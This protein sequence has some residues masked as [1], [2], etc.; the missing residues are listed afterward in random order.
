VPKDVDADD[1]PAFASAKSG[2]TTKL[3]Q[4]GTGRP[5]NRRLERPTSACDSH[6]ER[7][8][9][10]GGH[11]RAGPSRPALAGVDSAATRRRQ[12]G[13]GGRGSYRTAQ[14]DP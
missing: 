7:K 5:R 4:G 11:P 13:K 14:Y 8:R 3:T 12:R 2:M 10:R 6:R 9:L 1:K